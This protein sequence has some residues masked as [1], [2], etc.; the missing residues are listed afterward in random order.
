MNRSGPPSTSSAVPK[1]LNR[2]R[3]VTPAVAKPVATSAKKKKEDGG[4]QSTN[5]MHRGGTAE[6]ELGR[7]KVSE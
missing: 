6:H 7:A 5:Q 1:S 3:R 4:R 2:G